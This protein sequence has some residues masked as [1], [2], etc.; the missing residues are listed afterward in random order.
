MIASP[1]NRQFTDDPDLARSW[2]AENLVGRWGT[3][4]DVAAAALF[5]ASDGAEFV[6][7]EVITID[8]GATAALV[9]RGELD[10]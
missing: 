4:E 6:N 8:G 1:L 2:D 5:L 7:G 9:R 10:N 3:P